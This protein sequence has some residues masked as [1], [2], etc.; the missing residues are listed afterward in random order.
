MHRV[1]PRGGA[2]G[3]AAMSGDILSN[4]IGGKRMAAWFP[5]EKGVQESGCG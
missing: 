3:S 5:H 4:R 1:A 2:C